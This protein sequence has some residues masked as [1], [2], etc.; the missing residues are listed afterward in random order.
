MHTVYAPSDH[1][2]PAIASESAAS[3]S[4]AK[5]VPK[6]GVAPAKATAPNTAD[7]PKAKDSSTE[8]IV[9]ASPV[10]LA[11]SAAAPVYAGKFDWYSTLLPFL[12]REYLPAGTRKPRYPELYTAL[13]KVQ[14]KPDFSG[15]LALS[16]SG[17][18]GAF[19]TSDIVN[20]MSDGPLEDPIYVLHGKTLDISLGGKEMP[21]GQEG[22]AGTFK[23]GYKCDLEMDI[24][25][26]GACGAGMIS[27]VTGTLKMRRVWCDG[28]KELFEGY[29]GAHIT[30]GPTLRRKGHGAGNP[31]KTPIWA[32]RARRDE[33]GKEI[34]IDEGDGSYRG[35]GGG[36]GGFD[37]FDLDDDDDDDDGY[38]GGHY[39][40][41]DDFDYY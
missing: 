25:G 27:A 31:W 41:D 16:E 20:P 14:A 40:S 28:D 38:G 23:Q 13:L 19:A 9:T 5:P 17:A 37:N 33:Q 11:R 34:G 32:I 24:G 2:L 30:H 12:H 15:R 35:S 39:G 6:T 7:A 21:K 29:I 26:S 4:S 18:T 36:R 22:A 3:K 10:T 1:Y 8:D